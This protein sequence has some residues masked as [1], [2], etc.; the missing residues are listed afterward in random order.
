MGGRGSAKKLLEEGKTKVRYG[1]S[2]LER[3]LL[4]VVDEADGKARATGSERG[5][6][7]G[8]VTFDG[9]SSDRTCFATLPAHGNASLRNV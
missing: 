5:N 8:C 1:V 7:N 3:A 6:G 2:L 9:A 4:V